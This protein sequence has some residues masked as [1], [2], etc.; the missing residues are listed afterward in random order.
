M[1]KGLS[2]QIFLCFL[3]SFLFL[4]SKG[5]DDTVGGRFGEEEVD[6][7]HNHSLKAGVLGHTNGWGIEVL[8]ARNKTRSRNTLYHFDYLFSL[9]HPKETKIVNKQYDQASPYVFGRRNALMVARAGWGQQYRIAEKEENLGVRVDFNFTMGPNLGLL[10]PVYIEV[11]K[12]DSENQLERKVERYDPDKHVNQAKIFGGASY[13]VGMSEIQ[14]QPGLSSK[15]SLSFDWKE[16]KSLEAGVMVDAFP[17][18]M[19]IFAFVENKQL[20]INLYLSFS[21]GNR[22]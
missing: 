1:T 16:F 8:Y 11:I 5:Q 18:K 7:R 2:K 22:W 3:A 20:F 15:V 19:P 13:L 10:K 14:F 12:E 17:R 6:I 21:F 4:T 9:K